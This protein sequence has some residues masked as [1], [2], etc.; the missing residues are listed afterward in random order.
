LPNKQGIEIEEIKKTQ[1]NHPKVLRQK[2]DPKKP[3]T[4]E[5]MALPKNLEQENREFPRVST[6]VVMEQFVFFEK[7][8]LYPPRKAANRRARGKKV[9]THRR[10]KSPVREN[11]MSL[12]N[13]VAYYAD[14]LK[15]LTASWLPPPLPRRFRR[16]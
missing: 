4:I 5:K 13:Q 2:L 9:S 16:A 8:A 14:Y 6:R 7:Y 15:S 11:R 12:K 10:R 1:T 3:L